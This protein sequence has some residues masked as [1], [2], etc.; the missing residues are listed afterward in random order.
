MNTNIEHAIALIGKELHGDEAL[1]HGELEHIRLALICAR[2]L[3]LENARLRDALERRH[4]EQAYP[5]PDYVR[6]V[7]ANIG[8]DRHRRREAP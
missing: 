8:D 3:E 1:K 4:R 2:E 7:L 5:M 6:A